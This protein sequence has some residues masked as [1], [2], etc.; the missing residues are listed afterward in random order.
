M[1]EVT[2]IRTC[3]ATVLVALLF[4]CAAQ[5]AQQKGPGQAHD[6]TDI[7]LPAN[8][9]EVPNVPPV[10]RVSGGQ[11]L[12]F[13]LAAPSQAAGRTVIAFGEAAFVDHQGRRIYSMQLNPGSN[14]FTA[15]PFADGVCHGPQGCRFV[16]V[17]IGNP[18]R[19]AIIG[20]PIV[21][22]DP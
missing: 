20:S 12:D 13:H 1:R 3:I 7:D 22:I 21:I 14:R 2:S 6:R 15:R 10:T 9:E 11:S 17:N 4:G 18:Q 8:I 5:P 16:V 19:P